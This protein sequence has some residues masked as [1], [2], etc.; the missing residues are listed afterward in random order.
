[1]LHAK[2]FDKDGSSLL[3]SFYLLFYNHFPPDFG[4]LTDDLGRPMN[5]EMPPAPHQFQSNYSPDQRMYQQ[6]FAPQRSPAGMVRPFA[7]HHGNPPELWNGAEGPE[8]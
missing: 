3:L 6:N 1:M 2:V 7:M 5:P 8:N 4:S